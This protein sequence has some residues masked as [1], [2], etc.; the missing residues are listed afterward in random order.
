MLMEIAMHCMFVVRC[1]YD[2]FAKRKSVVHFETIC[3]LSIETRKNVNYEVLTGRYNYH[4]LHFCV[5]INGIQ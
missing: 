1:M 2:R 3:P 5:S 4:E